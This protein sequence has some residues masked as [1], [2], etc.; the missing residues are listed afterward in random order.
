MTAGWSVVALVALAGVAQAQE[1]PRVSPEMR[2]KVVALA[3][4]CHADIQALCPKAEPGGGRIYQ[5]LKARESELS[6]GCSS[7]LA[8][9]RQMF[10]GARQ[11][12]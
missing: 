10:A 2:A 6:S 3:E 9:A 7:A 11:G 1:A 5:C 4:V 12:G 8:Q